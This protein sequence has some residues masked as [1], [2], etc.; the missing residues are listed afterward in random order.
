MLFRLLCALTLVFT[1]LPSTL[2]YSAAPDAPPGSVAVPQSR[3]LPADPLTPSAAQPD[4]DM[5]VAPATD[6]PTE[7][8]ENAFIKML[9][10]L[11]VLV[12]LIFFTVWMLRR[13]SQGRFRMLGRGETM[14]IIDR[15]PLSAKTMLYVIEVKGKE[16]LIVE[17]QLEVRR[18]MSFE[19]PNE[20]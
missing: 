17:S 11:V 10:T 16:M 13:L 18:L 12:I 7:S 5:A 4:S 6:L 3:G 8:Y 20:E 15:K 19:E 1:T 2:I 14:K 9:V